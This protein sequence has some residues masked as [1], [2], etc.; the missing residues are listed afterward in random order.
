VE[1]EVAGEVE[2]ADDPSGGSPGRPG[3]ASPPIARVVILVIR[4]PSRPAIGGPGSA[5]A[6]GFGAAVATAGRRVEPRR[7]E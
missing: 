4:P 1:R 6:F 2:P 3:A 7:S 5:D